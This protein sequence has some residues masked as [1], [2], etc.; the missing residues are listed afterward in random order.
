MIQFK[1]SKLYSNR[2]KTKINPKPSKVYYIKNKDYPELMIKYYNNLKAIIYNKILKNKFRY[3]AV[4]FRSSNQIGLNWRVNYQIGLIQMKW[5]NFKKTNVFKHQVKTQSNLMS[6][7]N[8]NSL[9][10]SLI[11]DL[12]LSIF[13]SNILL[14]V[15]SIFP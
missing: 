6:K 2:I 5:V 12:V 13:I 10:N 1:K 7:S 4:M 14:T 9:N 8:N 11:I 15:I 3:R